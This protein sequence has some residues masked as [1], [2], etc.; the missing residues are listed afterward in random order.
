[1]AIDRLLEEGY[2]AGIA[3]EQGFVGTDLEETLLLGFTE[4][5]TR[6][7]IDAFSAS[8]AKVVK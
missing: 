4:R 3:L 8:L 7:E 1:V 5:R 2:L 6:S